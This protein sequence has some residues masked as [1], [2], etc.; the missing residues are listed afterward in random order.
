MKVIG[1][2][3]GIAT[4]KSTVASW[5]KSQGVPVIDADLL[6]REVLTAEIVQEAFGPEFIFDGQ[7]DRKKLGDYV[8]SNPDQRLKLEALTHP[9]IAQKLQEKLE[10]L[11]AAGHKLVIYEAAL[12]FEKNLQDRFDATILVVV[13]E[14]VQVERLLNRDKEL[15]QSSALKRIRSQMPQKKKVL[16]AT[17]VF[18]NTQTFK[19]SNTKLNKI[20]C[21]L[22]K[23]I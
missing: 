23:K 1:L 12:I 14:L 21:N 10:E 18:D 22:K 6:A 8:F 11:K 19:K 15:S 2:T 13:P 7:I 4:G 9:L 5:F 16:S 3:G 17:Y 20:Y